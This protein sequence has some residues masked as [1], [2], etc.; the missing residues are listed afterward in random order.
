MYYASF[1][2]RNYSIYKI[3][4]WNQDFCPAKYNCFHKSIIKKPFI[5]SFDFSVCTLVESHPFPILNSTYSMI[6]FGKN[7]HF[8]ARVSNQNSSA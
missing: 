6:E 7:G 4:T 3:D 8:V 5:K 2:R 1:G